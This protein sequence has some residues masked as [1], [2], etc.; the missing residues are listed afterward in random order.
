M[1]VQGSSSSAGAYSMYA[2]TGECAGIGR[3]G[4]HSVRNPSV[5]ALGERDESLV[6]ARGEIGFT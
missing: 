3:R 1:R 6:H 4:A 5:A 2:V